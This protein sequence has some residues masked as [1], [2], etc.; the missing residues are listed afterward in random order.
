MIYNLGIDFFS[1][2]KELFNKQDARGV[3]SIQTDEM[4]MKAGL[5]KKA[6][7]EQQ[8]DRALQL[9]DDLEKLRRDMETY[10]AEAVR[11]I[12]EQRLVH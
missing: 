6:Q 1:G 2:S 4:T 10:F 8:Y 3:L 9:Q 7:D 12:S 5:E 11:R